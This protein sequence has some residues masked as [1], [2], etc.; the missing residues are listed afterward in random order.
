[1]DQPIAC[2]LSD[3]ELQER[4][5]TVLSD[6]VG[7]IIQMRDLESGFAYQFPSTYLPTLAEII[8]FER[9]CCP[10]L[11][12]RIIAEPNNAP[13]WLEVIGPKG[14]AGWI[15]GELQVTDTVG[16]SSSLDLPYCRPSENA[17]GAPD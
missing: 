13:I 11:T 3:A 9:Q 14:S 5:K 8:R 16:Q 12:F 10:F 1:M 6:V 17:A 4:R 7:K 15:F 2:T